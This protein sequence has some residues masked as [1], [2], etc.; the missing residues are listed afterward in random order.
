MKRIPEPELMN[1]P[2]Q[3]RAY[4]NAD[5]DDPHNMFIQLFAARFPDEE[6]KGHVLDLGCGPADISIRFARHYPECLIDGVDGASAML[7]QAEQAIQRAGLTDRIQLIEACISTVELPR[8]TYD[9]IISNSLLHHLHHPEVLWRLINTL[10]KSGM[11]V[12]IMDLMRPGS[13]TQALHL[14]DMYAKDEPDVLRKDFL[15]S[16]V[17]AFTREEIEQQLIEHNLQY[18]DVRI[19]SDR[20]LSI[21][22]ITNA[23]I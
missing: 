11:K 15:N 9:A 2:E 18:L 20:H 19:E 6:I 13:K 22:G 8:P 3:A 21:S 5:F 23:Q 1:D 14:V 16:L 4:A 12:F 10:G 7:T 17:A